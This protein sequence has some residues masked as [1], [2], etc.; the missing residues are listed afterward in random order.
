MNTTETTT[1]PVLLFPGQGG[2][3]GPALHAA[4]TR[5]AE[6]AGILDAVD[7]VAVDAFDHKLTDVLFG[8]GPLDSAALL[9]EAPWVSQL[10]VYASGLAAH[11]VLREAGVTPSVLVGHSLGEITALVAAGSFG[12]EDGARIVLRRT[13]AVAGAGIRDGAMVAVTASAGRCAHLIGLLDDPR[14]VVAAV[15]HEAQTVLS[16]P[17]SAM[18]EV[19]A[20]GAGLGIGVIDLDAPFAFHHPALAGCAEEFAE[21]VRGLPVSAPAVPVYSP[22]LGRRYRPEDDL[23]ELLAAHFTRPVDFAGA[24]REL[25]AGG[26]R[27]FVECGGRGTL[28]GSVRKAVGEADGLLTL[29]T[30]LTAKDGA[31]ALDGSLERLRELGAAEGLAAPSLRGVLAPT[32]TD[33]EFEEF[34]SARGGEVLALV[35]GLAGEFRA[36]GSPAGADTATATGPAADA[37]SGGAVEPA[38][39]WDREELLA[40][41][42]TLYASALEYPEDVFTPEALLEAE[43]GVDSVKQV[44]LLTRA[45]RRFGLPA[46][47]EFKLAEY[48]TLDRIVDLLDSELAR[49]GLDRVAA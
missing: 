9:R 43:L 37:P 13:E 16:G 23:A 35:S 48:D 38:S 30:L 26:E 6:V 12:V 31:L 20:V 3:D 11:R 27:L 8:S 22:I 19:R 45:S 10:A 47:T 4:R 34:W 39:R 5:Y 42:R 18:I 24:V 2:Y 41:V 1:R 14:L 44:E 46:P 7:A 21:F 29:A 49:T 33:A 32:L 36:I 28:I 40:E 25:H 17:R 15:N